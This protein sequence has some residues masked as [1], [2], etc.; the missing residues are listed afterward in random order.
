MNS[1][2]NNIKV[3]RQGGNTECSN[4]ST[5]LESLD[6]GALRQIENQVQKIFEFVNSIIEITVQSH[7]QYNEL[8]QLFN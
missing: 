7:E 3:I 5:V 8:V 1:F 2:I 4:P 6:E